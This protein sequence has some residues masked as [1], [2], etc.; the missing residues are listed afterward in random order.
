MVTPE[1][2]TRHG[3]IGR[4]VRVVD[5]ANPEL[6]GIAGRVASESERT[7]V[8]RGPTGSGVTDRRVVKRD[9]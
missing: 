3:L 5:A 2:L 9:T 4:P 1:T 6:V 7:L 8:V